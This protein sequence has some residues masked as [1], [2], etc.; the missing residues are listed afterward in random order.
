MM[1]RGRAIVAA[2]LLASACAFADDKPKD[3]LQRVQ[4]K[5]DWDPAMKQSDAIPQILLERAVIQGNSLDFHY[6]FDGKRFTTSTEITLYPG[7]TPKRIDFTPKD[8]ANKGKT[9]LGLYE[10]NDGKLRICYRGPGSTRPTPRS[11]R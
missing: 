10:I 8:G 11:T 7:T 2:A 9:Y 6:I 3:D 1:L 5:W 4:G